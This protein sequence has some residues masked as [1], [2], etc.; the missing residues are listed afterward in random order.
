MSFANDRKERQKKERKKERKRKRTNE[1]RK[2]IEISFAGAVATMYRVELGRR[3]GC[4]TN[5][6]GKAWG[7]RG[8][9]NEEIANATK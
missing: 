4:G 2:V 3:I 8:T 7:G 9:G 1:R 6:D 5:S